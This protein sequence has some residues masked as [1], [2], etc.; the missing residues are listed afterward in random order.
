MDV[1]NAEVVV[2]VEVAL[3]SLLNLWRNLV[4]EWNAEEVVVEEE[5]TKS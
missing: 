1:Q 5:E 4:K 2:E 3:V